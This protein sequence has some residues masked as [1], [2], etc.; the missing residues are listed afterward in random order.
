MSRLF[1]LLL[2][3]LAWL[4]VC[5]SSGTALPL[6]PAE[7]AAAGQRDLGAAAATAPHIHLGQ[8]ITAAAAAGAVLPFEV[9]QSTA[10]D[11]L[12]RSA[13]VSRRLTASNASVA[14]ASTATTAAAQPQAQPATANNTQQADAASP[15]WHHASCDVLAAGIGATSSG[16]RAPPRA[17]PVVYDVTALLLLQGRLRL[18]P[19]ACIF[20]PSVARLG[21]QD[22]SS[23]AAAAE[24]AEAAAAEATAATT[25]QQR[26]A[27]ASDDGAAPAGPTGAAAAA[28]EDDGTLFLW[29]ARVYEG[30]AV[31][32]GGAASRGV[33]CQGPMAADGAWAN[34]WRNS[35]HYIVTAVVRHDPCSG[36][37]LRVLHA[38]SHAGSAL[39][40][41]RLFRDGA[42]QLQLLH[43]L[44]QRRHVVY[45]THVRVT[46][47][48]RAPPAAP[49][50]SS[51]N[52][53]AAGAATAPFSVQL[54]SATRLWFAK[55][56]HHEKNW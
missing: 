51:G 53:T 35:K 21:P 17:A 45:V 23:H 3:P 36:A 24:A 39:L 22:L 41:A 46:P 28:A 6:L 10:R 1:L 54:G 25:V 49:G 26:V 33:G 32:G 42:G 37:P 4:L 34:A 16:P 7:A 19:R 9:Q 8:R 43:T 30:P 27:L 15:G 38:S 29:V 14:S 20:N 11:S 12:L 50:N 13:P 52:A 18:P 55:A 5:G 40:D 56:A 2:P 48:P 44:W 47:A 31:R